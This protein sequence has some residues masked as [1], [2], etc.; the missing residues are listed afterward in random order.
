M[1]AAYGHW[2]QQLRVAKSGEG[3]RWAGGGGGGEV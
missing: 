1:Q 3:G 2:D